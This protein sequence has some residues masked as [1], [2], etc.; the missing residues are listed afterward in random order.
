MIFVAT[1]QEK[2]CTF[3]VDNNN[4]I[5]A[6]TQPRIGVLVACSDL[7]IS[8]RKLPILRTLNLH[9]YCTHAG[10]KPALTPKCKPTKSFPLFQVNVE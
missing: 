8:F 1:H 2:Q 10:H 7:H 3:I 4:V 6:K 5:P 9:T